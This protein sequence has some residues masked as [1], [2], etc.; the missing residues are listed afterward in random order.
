MRK[1]CAERDDGKGVGEKAGLAR[2]KM[3][4]KSCFKI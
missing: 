3:S 1:E 2:R 4:Q